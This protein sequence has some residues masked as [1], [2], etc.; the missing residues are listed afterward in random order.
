MT[1]SGSYARLM[2]RGRNERLKL[3]VGDEAE[4]VQ[5]RVPD[6][7]VDGE[8]A[9][10]GEV[11]VL[12]ARRQDNQQAAGALR[13]Q[14]SVTGGHHRLS[15]HVQRPS[16]HHDPTRRGFQPLVRFERSDDRAQKVCDGW[17]GVGHG[18]TMP[19][20][21]ASDRQIRVTSPT[22]T[23]VTGQR[24]MDGQPGPGSNSERLA[25]H[26]K[27]R[28]VAPGVDGGE[29][30]PLGTVEESEEGVHESVTAEVER[31]LACPT[32]ESVG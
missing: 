2:G 28:A 27:V 23:L 32:R 19:H 5:R 3:Q 4:V 25:R 29:S 7:A 9:V 1:M 15:T 20:H 14:R 18:E 30:D 6:E 13:G 24:D 8:P 17:Q 11:L 26:P 10:G 12:G 21:A 16:Q 22:G 31:R